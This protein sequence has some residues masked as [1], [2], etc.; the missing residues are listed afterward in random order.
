MTIITGDMGTG[1][2]LIAQGLAAQDSRFIIKEVASMK[3]VE[4]AIEATAGSG[5]GPIL[6]CASTFR[7]D[8]T[9]IRYSGSVYQIDTSRRYL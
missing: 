7:V 6:V 2:T 1:K 8:M 9:R 5:V 4:S 3:E